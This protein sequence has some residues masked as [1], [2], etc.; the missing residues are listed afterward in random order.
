M[1]GWVKITSVAA[2]LSRSLQSGGGALPPICYRYSKGRNFVQALVAVGGDPSGG[3]LFDFGVGIAEPPEHFAGVLARGGAGGGESSLR[4]WP[5]RRPG[6]PLSAS[7][8]RRGARHARRI[9]SRRGRGR[10]AG[11]RDR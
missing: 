6:S 10:R 11:P 5:K 3:D 4:V 2:G 1:R 9:Q 8:L 7:C